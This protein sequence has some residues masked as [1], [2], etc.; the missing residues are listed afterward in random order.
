MSLSNKV[1]I[2]DIADEIKG[3]RVLIRYRN[4]NGPLSAI[5]LCLLTTILL[6]SISMCFT[7]FPLKE[8]KQLT[9][10]QV[11]Q[12]KTPPYKITNNQRIVAALPTIKY[13]IDHQ[14]KTI[15]LMSHLGRPNGQRSEKYSLRPVAEELEKLLGRNVIFLDDCVGPEVEKRVAENENDC[16]QPPSPQTPARFI[17]DY[18]SSSHFA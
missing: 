10:Y 11:P 3:N 5:L 4:A 15:T 17:N 18:C 12:E 1:A 2:T 9:R 16:K 13:C 7:P 8:T 6:E 14:A